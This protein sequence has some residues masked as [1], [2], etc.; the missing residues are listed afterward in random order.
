[1]N[2]TTR[3]VSRTD[4]GERLLARLRPALDE[5]SGAVQDLGR[6]RQQ[7]FRRLAIV[8]V[9]TGMSELILPVWARFLADYPGVLLD[10]CVDANP[11]D[12]VAAG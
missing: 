6:D 5:I 2:R 9:H 8:T 1:M 4:P 10:V 7:P 12:I 3:N 11:H